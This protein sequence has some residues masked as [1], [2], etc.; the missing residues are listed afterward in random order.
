MI[1]QGNTMSHQAVAAPG[2]WPSPLT[3]R[4]LFSEAESISFPRPGRQG[5]F[6]LLT[7][8]SEGNAQVLMHLGHDGQRQRVS[9]PGFNLRSRVHEYGGCPYAVND[10]LVVFCNFSDQRLYQLRFDGST[11]EAPLAFGPAATDASLRH[12]DLQIDPQRQRL[13][14]VREDHSQPDDV[15]NTLVSIDL[16]QGGPGE[17]LFAESDFVAAPTLSPDGRRLAFISWNHPNMPWDDTRL[18]WLT[19]AADGSIQQ[20]QQLPLSQ[21]TALQQPAFDADGNL[22][23]IADGNDWWNLYRLPATAL[24]A[25]NQVQIEALCPIS[26]EC[27]A[28][29]WS[30]GLR[31]YCVSDTGSV[32]LAVNQNTA[33]QLMFKPAGD[34][35]WQRLEQDFGSIDGLH[36][37]GEDFVFAATGC[38][39]SPRLWSLKGQSQTLHSLYRCHQPALLPDAGISRAE[40]VSFTVSDGEQAYGLFYAPRHPDY[41]LQ[42]GELPPLLVMVHGG[43]TGCARPAYNPVIQFWTSRGFAVF[44]VNHRG[45]TGYG[46]KFRHRL[47]GHW[48]EIDV[49][50]VIAGIQHLIQAQRVDGQRVVIRGGSAGGFVVLAAMCQSRLFCAGTSYYGVSDLTLLAQDTHKF[51]SRYPDQLIG[52]WPAARTLYEQRS[53]IQQLEQISAPVLLLQG[54]EDRVV[55]PNQSR[56]I[57]AQLKT[58]Q[59]DSIYVEFAGEGHGFRQPENQIAALEKE[60]AFYQQ[61]ISS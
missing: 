26:A 7:C 34:L 59:P 8:A 47:Y 56:L 20:R 42:P 38:D 40:H 35:S 39:D 61:R 33:W 46:R 60:L 31:S 29:P 10:D 4:Q 16:Q 2:H 52:P 22:Y 51:E 48:G 41:Q 21:P 6:Y 9:P 44:D 58:L 30:L 36:A 1:W 28:A 24:D 5:T 25:P 13:I 55:P 12:A 18:H 17:T 19:L 32:V 14:A 54:D 3:S 57:F 27:G 11:A 15:R 50:D 43:P 45:S 53:P 23:F 49:A 37:A